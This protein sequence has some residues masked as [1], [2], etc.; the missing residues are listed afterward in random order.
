MPTWPTKGPAH[1]LPNI[2]H[3]PFRVDSYIDQTILLGNNNGLLVR[4][5]HTEQQK[6]IVAIMTVMPLPPSTPPSNTVAPWPL[7]ASSE[8]EWQQLHP[9]TISCRGPGPQPAA[10]PPCSN[11]SNPPYLELQST[12]VTSHH[13]PKAF[14]KTPTTSVKPTPILGHW[15]HTLESRFLTLTFCKDCSTIVQSFLLNLMAHLAGENKK[16]GTIKV[17]YQNLPVKSNY[18]SYLVQRYGD[19]HLFSL[20]QNYRI[21]PVSPV[22]SW[23]SF[24][25]PSRLAFSQYDQCR[26]IGPVLQGTLH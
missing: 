11:C 9:C 14:R 2:S 17:V 26:H 12:H 23:Q 1:P 8:G 10:V 22:T 7:L 3:L 24:A 18:V 15:Q 6:H 25:F 5:T 19:I 4:Q 16:G 21:F 13:A 20:R